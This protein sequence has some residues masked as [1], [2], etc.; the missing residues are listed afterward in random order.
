[1][2]K[3]PSLLLL[4]LLSGFCLLAQK[5]FNANFEKLDPTTGKIQDWSLGIGGGTLGQYLL[6][7]DSTTSV[8]GR[9]SLRLDPL[10]SGGEFGAFHLRFPADFA[11]KTITLK[12]WIKTENIPEKSW[13]GL[14]MRLDGESED[15]AF[16]NM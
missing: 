15:V 3:K 4:F 6:T 1:M 5:N 10:P 8:S 7:V 2:M 13:A 14:W 9:N 11:G 12:G 16:D